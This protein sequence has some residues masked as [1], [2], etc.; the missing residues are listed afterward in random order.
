MRKR[1]DTS[2]A[3]EQPWDEPFCHHRHNSLGHQQDED[4]ENGAKHHIGIDDLLGADPRGQPRN[5]DA[6]D[7]RSDQ[8]SAPADH[9]PDD[10]LGRLHD[11]E[12]VR[13][14]IVAPDGEQASGKPR[15]S[16]SDCKRDELVEARVIP[17]ELD[18][19]LVLADGDEH[20]S[21]PGGK[22][23][24]QP[25]IDE[26]QQTHRHE[27][28]ALGIERSIREQRD[29]EGGDVGDA[30]EAAEQRF[31]DAIFRSGGAVDGI[32]EDERHRQR[33]DPD[34][35]IAHTRVKHEIAKA[36]RQR[37]RQRDG[38]QQRDR[39]FA[40][41]DACHRVSI[42]ANPEEGGM[43]ETKDAAI[44]P[45]ESETEREDRQDCVERDLQEIEKI[46]R[47]RQ[48]DQEGDAEGA[49]TGQIEM[50]A[51]QLGHK[52]PRK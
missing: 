27:I 21:E 18:P 30:I 13:A 16:A 34:I 8:R 15:Q 29:V 10:D 40:D 33:D 52:R 48:P 43:T 50:L 41:V 46:E 4:E 1:R 51:Q 28:H 24:V 6:A 42:G 37:R 12:D 38:D 22:Q 5:G 11:A 23:R 19:L 45:D 35:D 36:R 25:E 44:A 3:A 7:D 2:L 20:A 47:E 14:H 39:A 17:Q 26:Q 49:D 32:V 9:Q 31:P